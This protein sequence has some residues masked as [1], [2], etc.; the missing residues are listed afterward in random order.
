M[1]AAGGKAASP[2]RRGGKRCRSRRISSLVGRSTAIRLGE[3]ES[4][5]TES[6]TCSDC[7]LGDVTSPQL[8]A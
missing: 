7:A 6:V 5:Q 1:R 3:G 8:S 2:W 4:R